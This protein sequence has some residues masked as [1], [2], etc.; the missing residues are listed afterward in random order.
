MEPEDSL[1]YSQQSSIGHYPE[2]HESSL[3]H[4]PSYFCKIHFNIIL[5]LL[6]S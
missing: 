3:Y 4:P 5:P 6:A 2:P 1:P